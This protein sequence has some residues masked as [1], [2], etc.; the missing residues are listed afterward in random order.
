LWCDL[1][2]LLP[3]HELGHS[4]SQINQARECNRLVAYLILLA[5]GIFCVFVPRNLLTP[6]HLPTRYQ[7]LGW[8]GIGFSYLGLVLMVLAIT[9]S[10]RVL[11][12]IL[13]HNKEP[14]T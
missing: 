3:E 14:K 9:A 6:E 7:H 12:R 2:W 10:I 4:P 13:R 8:L 11:Y 5:L 1:L